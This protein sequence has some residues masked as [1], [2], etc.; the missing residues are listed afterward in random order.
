M[1][2]NGLQEVQPEHFFEYQGS[3]SWSAAREVRRARAIKI[4][5]IETRLSYLEDVY[6]LRNVL[7]HC[8]GLIEAGASAVLKHVKVVTGERVS[9][10]TDQLLELATPVIKIAEA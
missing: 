10:A 7:T 6:M 9:I 8:A 4:K 3:R 1:A 5:S 2:F